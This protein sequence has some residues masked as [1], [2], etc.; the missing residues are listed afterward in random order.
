MTEVLDAAESLAHALSGAAV[1]DLD[2]NCGEVCCEPGWA[3]DARMRDF[4]IWMVIA[5]EGAA[6]IDGRDYPLRAGTT[7]LLRP[8]LKVHATQNPD[9][10]LRVVFAHFQL[11]DPGTR[12]PIRLDDGVLPPVCTQLPATSPALNLMREIVA[13]DGRDGPLVPVARAARLTVVLVDLWQAGHDDAAGFAGPDPRIAAIMSAI[14]SEPGN[15]HTL[16]QAADLMNL[17]PQHF[18]RLFRKAAG[19]S[20]R[21]FCLSA[22]LDRAR[23]LLLDTPMT[24]TAIARALGYSDVHLMSRQ[25]RARFGKSPR[26]LRCTSALPQKLRTRDR[27]ER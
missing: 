17:G 13:L 20:Y 15:R 10:R 25:M 26:E 2:R 24:V 23:Q 27:P 1:P 7:L 4:D 22:R 14:R 11:V 12:R 6:T 8:G 19:V 18:S 3:W 21:E 16:A 9:R 5:G